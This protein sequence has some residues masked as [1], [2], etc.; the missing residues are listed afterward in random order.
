MI[1]TY[2]EPF[3]PGLQFVDQPRLDAALHVSPV[4]SV[5]RFLQCKPVDGVI[6]IDF[7]LLKEQCQEIHLFFSLHKLTLKNSKNGFRIGVDQVAR[8]NPGV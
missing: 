4:A 8:K 6:C 5:K 2:G 1:T 7:V 3:I